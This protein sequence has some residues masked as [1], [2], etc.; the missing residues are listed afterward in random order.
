M[1]FSQQAPG[2]HGPTLVL[3]NSLRATVD[4]DWHDYETVKSKGNPLIRDLFFTSNQ[5]DIKDMNAN[6]TNEKLAAAPFSSFAPLTAE[7]QH[8]SARL[9]ALRRL[10]ILD[11]PDEKAYDT[12][13][14]AAADIC[15][16]PIAL[17]SFV[18]ADRQWFKSRIGV[19]PHETPR[20]ISFC[21]HAIQNP[22]TIMIVPDTLQD[23]RFAT[24]PL[25]TSAPNVRFYAGAPLS[26]GDG[27]AV[28]TLCILDTVPRALSVDQLDVLEFFA[29]Q[30]M[31]MLKIRSVWTNAAGDRTHLW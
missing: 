16:V 22:S 30:A 14:H 2:E 26:T 10:R 31:K 21:N 15:E 11:S 28:G 24:N 6:L 29:G 23:E 8:E 17:I 18:D 3:N 1:P 5:C 9:T 27:Y 13:T 4:S 19:G 25:V 20:A 7:L 12:I